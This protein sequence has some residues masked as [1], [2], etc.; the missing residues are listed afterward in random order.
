MSSPPAYDSAPPSYDGAPREYTA[1]ASEDNFETEVTERL[2][3]DQLDMD[4]FDHESSRKGEKLMEGNDMQRS[5]LMSFTFL[6]VTVMLLLYASISGTVVGINSGLISQIK[7][8][9][10]GQ[11]DAQA[12]STLDEAGEYVTRVL[13]QYDQAVISYTAFAVNNALRIDPEFD[14]AYNISNYWDD[15]RGLDQLCQPVA[16]DPPRHTVNK[17]SKCGSSAFITNGNYSDIGTWDAADGPETLDIIN[18]TTV[19]DPFLRHMYE[20]NTD[21]W[22]IYAG[23]NTTP[24]FFRRYPGRAVQASYNSTGY[25]PKLRPWYIEALRLESQGTSYTAPYQDYNTRDWMITGARP[26]YFY[27]RMGDRYNG[28]MSDD[29]YPTE[30]DPYGRLAGVAGADILIATIS[31]TLNSINFL[32]SGKLTLLRTDGQVV[33]DNDWDI[34]TS[35]SA[36]YY[37][38]LANP[39]VSQSL[40]SQISAVAAGVTKKISYEKTSG[41]SQYHRRVAYVKHL[42]VYDE[43]YILVVFISTN[44]I[45]S[46]IRDAI[47]ELKSINLTVLTSM[48]IG[49]AVMFAVLL[50]FMFYLIRSIMKVFSGIENNV[51]QLLRN[52]GQAGRT[53]GSDM[54]EVDAGASSELTQLST[55]M[56]DMMHHLQASRAA[57]KDVAVGK[58][59]RPAPTLA[60]MWGFVPMDHKIDSSAPPSYL[61]P[62]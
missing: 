11:I 37:Y 40:W 60:E 45:Y 52:V 58:G 39:P 4:N 28:S 32:Q 9:L 7:E 10:N 61:A 5:I 35:D 18:K 21:V 31:E 29:M 19:L 1:A 34:S 55:N 16:Y 2:L 56:N 20:V 50:L 47:D 36:F 44:E 38:D 48:G 62:K 25:D 24:S 41:P 12:Y 17:I 59:G 15:D 42:D 53:L 46:P 30:P 26:F 51:E 23:F 57:P 14:Q 43:Q 8:E 3:E 6:G 27:E 33:V 22:Q 49:L 13:N 54:V